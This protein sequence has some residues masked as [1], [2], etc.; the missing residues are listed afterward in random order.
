MIVTRSG[1]RA[2]RRAARTAPRRGPSPTISS[3]A[4]IPRSRTSWARIST[5]RST[6]SCSP[7]SPRNTSLA[8]P[9]GADERWSANHTGGQLRTT[10]TRRASDCTSSRCVSLVVIVRSAVRADCRR[11][12]ASIDSTSVGRPSLARS[13]PAASSWWSKTLD[14]PRRRASQSSG[15]KKSG[16]LCTCSVP[17]RARASRG[18]TAAVTAQHATRYSTAVPASVPRPSIRRKARYAN[19]ANDLAGRPVGLT[20]RQDLHRQAGLRR[21][22]RPPGERERPAGRRCS[23]APSR[24]LRRPAHGCSCARCPRLGDRGLSVRVHGS[25][26]HETMSRCSSFRLASPRIARSIRGPQKTPAPC[27][28][29]P[30][31]SVASTSASSLDGP[32][33]AIAGAYGGHAWHRTIHHYSQRKEN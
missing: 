15:K 22:S 13:M 31:K 28:C 23:R 6:R 33:R 32:P 12:H 8:R 24:H 5:A 9:V 18:S 11:I 17:R 4:S 7:S 26:L 10:S 20:G 21:G 29:L 19:A 2:A 27:R 1:C 3:S 25:C 30:L 16:G 14:Q